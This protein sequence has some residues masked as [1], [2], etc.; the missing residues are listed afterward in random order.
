MSNAGQANPS[1]RI[2]VDS[3]EAIMTS[4]LRLSQAFEPFLRRIAADGRTDSSIWSYRRQLHLLMQDL[5]DIRL[6]SITPHH[7]CRGCSSMCFSGMSRACRRSNLM[8]TTISFGDGTANRSH[9]EPCNTALRSGYVG[10]ESE[11]GF[12]FIHFGIHSGPC[13]T[14][15]RGTSSWSVAPSGTAT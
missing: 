15:Q 4:P 9:R 6:A 11:R 14:K 5:H 1:Y 2:F 3:Q 8:W 12:R 10:P 7:L 13:S